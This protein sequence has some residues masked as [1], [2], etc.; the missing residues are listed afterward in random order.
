VLGPGPL[1]QLAAEAGCAG[2]ALDGGCRLPEIPLVA[3]AAFRQRLTMPLLVAPMAETKLAPGRRLPSLAALGNREERA[4][5]VEMV[6]QAI[7]VS[8]DL[9]TK[10]IVLDFGRVALQVDE[11]QIRAHFARRELEEDEAGRPAFDAA[12]KERRARGEALLD[13]CR[14]ALDPLVREAERHAVRLALLPA[15]TPWQ[16]PSPRETTT[17]LEDFAG[18]PVATVFSP[19]RLMVLASLGLGV[20]RERSDALKR[21]AAVVEAADV[22][23]L[24][25]PLLLGLGEL[26]PAEL[27]GA[28]DDALFVLTGPTGATD[29]EVAGVRKMLEDRSPTPAAP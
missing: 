3:A 26:D 9:G 16:V 14:A 24:E 12:L 21:A 22:V 15:A 7:E 2:V 11:A 5:A 4:A 8:R 10:T 27:D 17:L 25:L 13:A 23:G 19:A 1:V 20:S 6:R 29:E 28:P 18:A